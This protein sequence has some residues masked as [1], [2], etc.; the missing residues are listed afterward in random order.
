[1]TEFARA[2]QQ[3]VN[4]ASGHEYT[5]SFD[6]LAG[7]MDGCTVEIGTSE[8][9]DDVLV[10]TTDDYPNPKSYSGTFTAPSSGLWL[11]VELVT[12]SGPPYSGEFDNISVQG[13]SSLV[14]E[15]PNRTV[16][17]EA[18]EGL[19][20]DGIP[21]QTLLDAA[22]EYITHDPIT[23]VDRQPLGLTDDT[24][25]VEPITRQGFYV[26]VRSL[27]ISATAEALAKAQITTDLTTYFKE[28]TPFVDGVDVD[29]DRVDTISTLS[30]SIIV[31]EAL[32]QHGGTASGIGLGIQPG[33]YVNEY[34]LLP[35]QMAKLIAVNYV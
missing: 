3:L 14:S 10:L 34:T 15:P 13:Y 32:K 9:D 22:R 19:G 26:E 12:A 6:A 1:M 7:T 20:V 11:G 29:I 17:I 16:F 30:V 21:T 24:L 4:I 31:Q 25:H 2:D 8:G 27:V 23:G 28:I 18:Q 5:L 33:Q 35:G